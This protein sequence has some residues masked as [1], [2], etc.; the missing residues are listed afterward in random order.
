MTES[1]PSQSLLIIGVVRHNFKT[2]KK[3][4]EEQQT[5]EPNDRPGIGPRVRRLCRC[6]WLWPTRVPHD[7]DDDDAPFGAHPGGNASGHAFRTKTV[8]T[9]LIGV[10]PLKVPIV[11]A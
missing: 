4:L 3:K 5:P 8:L 11:Y 10:P 9:W 2:K 6:W 7:C 1:M